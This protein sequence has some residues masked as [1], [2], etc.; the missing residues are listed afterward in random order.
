MKTQKTVK[1]MVEI[2]VPEFVTTDEGPYDT[3]LGEYCLVMCLNYMY[4]GTVTGV[5]GQVLVLSE[6]SLVYETGPWA[7]KS[8][9]DAQRLPTD[10]CRV[11]LEHI[12]NAFVVIR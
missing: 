2:E 11:R 12:E 8:W 10:E 9:K 4:A 3:L 6:P 7:N 1:R 5:N